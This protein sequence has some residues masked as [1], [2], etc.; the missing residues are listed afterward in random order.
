[1]MTLIVHV[2]DGYL[3]QEANSRSLISVTWV[4]RLSRSVYAE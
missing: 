2:S 3:L 4:H 1:M